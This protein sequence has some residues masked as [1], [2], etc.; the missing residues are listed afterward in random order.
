[1]HTAWTGSFAYKHIHA[2]FF[3]DWILSNTASRISKNFFSK[4]NNKINHFLSSTCKLEFF[5]VFSHSHRN[6]VFRKYI[7]IYLNTF[8]IFFETKIYVLNNVFVFFF[9]FFQNIQRSYQMK[10]FKKWITK[11]R[12]YKLN[13]YETINNYR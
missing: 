7:S 4:I 9:C 3:N 6:I 13:N 5:F 10:R 8:S 2:C 11:C 12:F 1:M